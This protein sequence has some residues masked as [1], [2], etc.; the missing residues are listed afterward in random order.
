MSRSDVFFHFRQKRTE[1]ENN[2]NLHADCLG[3]LHSKQYQR[4]NPSHSS[5]VSSEPVQNLCSKKSSS[6]SAHHQ[7]RSVVERANQLDD[8]TLVCYVSNQQTL[9]WINYENRR[10]VYII[11]THTTGLLKLLLSPVVNISLSSG[12]SSL[13]VPTQSFVISKFCS[14]EF[15]LH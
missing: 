3:V 12:I 6:P 9:V 13:F 4:Y 14:F 7:P 10:T 11:H 8:H 2:Y 5:S 15:V 1:S